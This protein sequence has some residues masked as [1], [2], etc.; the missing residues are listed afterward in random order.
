MGVQ[1]GLAGPED[2]DAVSALAWRTFSGCYR[3]FLGDE[4]VDGYHESGAEDEELAKHF[5]DTH[6]LR[7]DGE[8][9]GLVVLVDDLIH[10]LLV[11]PERHRQ[12]HATSLMDYAEELLAARGHRRARLESFTAN[13][14]AMAFYRAQG[15]TEV[16]RGPAPE[17]PEQ[18]IAYLE[19]DLP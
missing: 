8:L 16:R 1:I 9:V 10:L 11:D 13:L 3:S 18:E 2:R 19:K 5:G 14:P 6:L 17:M 15:W 12:G 4:A 7:A